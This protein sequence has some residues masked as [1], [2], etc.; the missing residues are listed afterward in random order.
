MSTSGES[1]ANWLR[2]NKPDQA[3][4]QHMIEKLAKRIEESDHDEARLQ[5]SIEAM[6]VLEAALGE[7]VA[8]STTEPPQLDTSPLLDH[9]HIAPERPA[10][11]KQA[12]FREL[13]NK[14]DQR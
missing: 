3:T 11:E 7:P 5:G 6:D 8:D 1:A 14:L 13:K 4:I 10:E 2:E 12:I 9:S